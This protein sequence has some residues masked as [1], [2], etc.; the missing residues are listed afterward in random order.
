MKN[1]RDMLV[2]YGLGLAVTLGG[3]VLVRAARPDGTP[4]ELLLAGLVLLGFPLIHV[5]L[6]SFGFR[7]DG[8]AL[9]VVM[10]LSGL[11]LMEIFRLQPTGMVRQAGWILLGLGVMLLT[12]R[13]ACDPDRL[14][15]YRYLWAAGATV[16]L[17]SALLFGTERGGARQWIDLGAVSFQPSEAVKVL[18]VLF[19]AAYLCEHQPVLIPHL[20]HDV[21]LRALAPLGAVLGLSLLMLVIQRDLGGALLY[22][23]IVLVMVYLGT[24]RADYVAA[25]AV[26]FLVGGGIC[27]ALFPHVRVRLD[28]WLDPW[29]DLPGVGYQTAQALFALGSGGI[30]GTGLGLGH[31]D[32]VPAA[33]TDLILAAIGEELGYVGVLCV[34]VLYVLLIGWG[35]CVALRAQAPFSRLVAA[36]A[37]TVLGVQV[38]LILGG[39]LRFVPLTGI[40][41][42]F[43]SYGGS[44]IV[45]NFVLLGLLLGVS[46][47][48]EADRGVDRGRAHP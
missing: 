5:V 23:V 33:H 36:G 3:L 39:S 41:L 29:R 9:P 7:G 47:R 40:T 20:P 43:V 15:R 17:G 12:Y 25:G 1:A 16:L 31:P 48:E 35:F 6:N 32:L 26:S 45:S 4:W 42:P 27:Y 14:G 38:V 28:A 44:S 24:G 34:V 13:L 8:F 19:L 10:G 2:L 37:S 21:E 30:V 11:G 18:L 46:H 22:F